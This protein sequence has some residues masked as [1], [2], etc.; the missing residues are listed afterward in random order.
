[1]AKLEELYMAQNLISIL[2]GWE[3]LP[4]LRKLHL[5]KNKI[6]KVPEEEMPDLPALEYINLRR[7]NI[8]NLEVIVKL[9]QFK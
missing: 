2:T 3:N 9:F 6:E 4:S 1:M 7:N 5:R 8:E